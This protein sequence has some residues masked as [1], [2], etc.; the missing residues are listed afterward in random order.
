MGVTARA[1]VDFAMSGRDAP[2][3]RPFENGMSGDQKAILED[4]DLFGQ[5]MHL[6]GP[7]FGRVGNGIEVAADADHALTTDAPLQLQDRPER[8]QRQRPQRR[9]FLGEGLANDTPRGGMRSGVDDRVEPMAELPVQI[10]EIAEG[11]GKEE[12][13]ADV[14]KRP[15]DLALGLRAVGLAGPGMEAVMPREI[16][17]GRL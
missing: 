10:V 4:T 17:E 1:T 9:L 16:D 5:R 2:L 8:R 14:T 11:S 6:D 13:L 12:V 3:M 7:A 15:L